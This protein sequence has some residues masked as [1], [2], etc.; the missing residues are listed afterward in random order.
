MR[1]PLS[2]L[3]LAALLVA[4]PAF[5]QANTGKVS[6]RVTA[7]GAGLPGVLITAGSPALQGER[8]TITKGNGDYVLPLLPAGDYSLSFELEGFSPVRQDV[9][10]SV[11]QQVPIDL[12][13][14]LS[15][16]SEEIVVTSETATI[17]RDIQS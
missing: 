9:K 2:F 3:I 8:T 11:N 14:V 4:V 10:V 13:M 6:G 5:S 15:E 17:S 12:T 1:R 16:L 7:E